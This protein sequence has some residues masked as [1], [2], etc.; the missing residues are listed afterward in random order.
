M[1]WASTSAGLP[2]VL[3]ITDHPSKPADVVT[4]TTSAGLLGWSVIT[5]T[6]GNP[7][8]VLAQLIAKAAN[9][10]TDTITFTATDDG[11]PVGTTVIHLIVFID[12]TFGVVFVPPV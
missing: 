6:S 2:E 3:V 4:V 1:S 5:N 8:D 9:H 12:T 7:A 11:I 10:G